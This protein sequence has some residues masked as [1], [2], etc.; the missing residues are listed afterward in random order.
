MQCD[1]CML[2]A[3][4]GSPRQCSQRKSCHILLTEL[5][6]SKHTSPSHFDAYCLTNKMEFV[7]METSLVSTV[8]TGDLKLE[9]G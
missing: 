5:C 2:L 8:P 9:P 6:M 7:I 4:D 3:T 1:I